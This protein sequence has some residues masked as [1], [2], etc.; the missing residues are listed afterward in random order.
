MAGPGP[1]RYC[2]RRCGRASSR[3]CHILHLSMNRER[4]MV[5]DTIG[6]DCA[7]GLW[8]TSMS[9]AAGFSHSGCLGGCSHRS[10]RSHAP[11]RRRRFGVLTGKIWRRLGSN[12]RHG[13]YESL[14][15]GSPSFA[16]IRNPS[17]RRRKSGGA[18]SREWERSGAVIG[19]VDAQWMLAQRSSLSG[20]AVAVMGFNCS[21][22]FCSDSRSS[23]V[24]ALRGLASADLRR[25]KLSPSGRID[26]A[27]PPSRRARPTIRCLV[28]DVGI[29][30]GASTSTSVRL[31]IV[32]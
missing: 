27:V 25:Q 18:N 21:R 26:L 6:D 2:L 14:L 12:Q 9:H 32:A 22:S 13:A 31:T 11:Q 7:P 19:S 1:L 20:G 16:P 3:I 4:G 17:S 24:A 10:S 15:A 28:D 5:A 23:A 29:I 30:S 8:Q